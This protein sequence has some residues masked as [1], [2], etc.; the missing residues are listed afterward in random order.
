MWQILL[1]DGGHKPQCAQ[2]QLHKE[3]KLSALTQLCRFSS[4]WPPLLT[5]STNHSLWCCFEK[6]SFYSDSLY[7]KYSLTCG[8]TTCL[9]SP[10]RYKRKSIWCLTCRWKQ[11]SLMHRLFLYYQVICASG[12]LQ[13]TVRY[14]VHFS[15]I[16]LFLDNQWHQKFSE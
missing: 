7:E 13:S 9:Q 12:H 6:Q 4:T 3:I 5:C 2:T 1:C 8:H 14:E 15:F 10:P 16:C 11:C